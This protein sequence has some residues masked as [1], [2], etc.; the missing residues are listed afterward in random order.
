MEEQQIIDTLEVIRREAV[1]NAVNAF[2]EG[3]LL[4]MQYGK[5]FNKTIKTRRSGA[6]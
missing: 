2:N 1:K 4:G 6:K 3:Y 5:Q